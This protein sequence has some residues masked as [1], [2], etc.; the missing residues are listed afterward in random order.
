[1]PDEAIA[2]VCEAGGLITLAFD[3]AHAMSGGGAEVL[4]DSDDVVGEFGLMVV[5]AAERY[6][7]ANVAVG[8]RSAVVGDGRPG[9]D[10]VVDAIG[11]LGFSD[12]DVEAVTGGNWLDFYDRLAADH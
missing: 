3:G 7:V 1:M 10:A 5:E 4:I 12:Q 2:A 6:G 8:R 11:G 9:L